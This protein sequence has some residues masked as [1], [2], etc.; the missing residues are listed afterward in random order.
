MHRILLPVDGSASSERSVQ[1][2]IQDLDKQRE[3]AEIHVLYAQG[4]LSPRLYELGQ[5]QLIQNVLL[6][7]ARKTT[8]TARRLLSSKGLRHTVSVETGE[9]A[10]AIAAYAKAHGCDEIVMGTRGL[11]TMQNLMLGSVA[12]KVVHLV[13]VP[14]KLVK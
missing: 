14:V 9:P 6:E 7:D 2:L 1:H 8:E 12:A 11:G 4:D 3:P 13:D 5:P 10:A